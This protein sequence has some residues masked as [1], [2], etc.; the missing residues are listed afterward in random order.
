LIDTLGRA[1]APKKQTTSVAYEP[2]EP[3][4]HERIEGAPPRALL[5]DQTRAGVGSPAAYLGL[6]P[7]LQ[8]RY[9][10]SEDAMALGLSLDSLAR[11]CTTCN[12]SGVLHLDMS[13]LPDVHLTCE[14]CQGSGYLPEA[15]QVRMHGIPLPE[16]FTKTIDQV[17][18]LFGDDEK[19]ATSLRAAQAAGLGYLVL[20]QPGLSLS[21]G[22]AQRLKIA[23]ELMRKTPKD[24]LYILDEPSVGQHLEDVK[25][26]SEALHGLV[27]AGGSVIIV[28]HHPHLLASCDWLVEIGP[29]GG[30]EGGRLIA[31][32]RP[33]QLANGNTPIAR[34]LKEVL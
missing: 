18:Q 19:L 11:R 14:T 27:E 22:E 26:L 24:T 8:A 21:G 32:G 25:R 7:V 2:V 30:P 5:V 9:A 13:F 31:A 20:R 29:G 12:G 23:N 4:E 17:Y 10:E 28:E 16:I 6:A 34:Y 1:L 15:W 33:A 3:G